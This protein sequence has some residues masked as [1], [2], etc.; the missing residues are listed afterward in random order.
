MRTCIIAVRR[1]PGVIPVCCSIRK[2]FKS[3]GL[4]GGR[5]RCWQAMDLSWPCRRFTMSLNRPARRCLTI[6]RAR[7]ASNFLKTNTKEL[8][9]YDH[10]AR[11]AL[12]FLQSHAHCTGKLGVMGICIGGHLA[13]RAAM[14]PGVLAAVCFYATD[15]HTRSLAKGKNDNTLD[16]MKDVR[17]EMLM[18]W[19]H[20]GRSATCRREAGAPLFT[21]AMAD[22]RA[23]ISL[24]T[25]F[26]RPARLSARRRP[27]LRSFAA[28]APV[29][30]DGA[31]IV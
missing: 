31:G 29:L 30:R 16:R 9:S 25:E 23:C 14:N 3:R 15:I 27:P 21:N 6:R 12:D 2:S 10:D 20:S 7:S 11:A 4:F 5:R 19:G 8:A 13:F 22:S 17:A 26:Q 1:R 28:G 24:W 18:I